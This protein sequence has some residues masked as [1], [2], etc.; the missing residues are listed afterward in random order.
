MSRR[1]SVY[2]KQN[3]GK[4]RVRFPDELVFQE[5]VKDND[6]ESMHQMLRRASL[7]MD[8]SAV[9]TAGI[10]GRGINRQ[11]RRRRSDTAGFSVTLRLNIWFLAIVKF[12]IL[13]DRH[14]MVLRSS[15]LTFCFFPGRRHQN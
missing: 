9:N 5:N 13:W 12:H 8:L 15:N 6:V 10:N 2:K 1:A 7:K 3:P 14:S 4:P 11:Y